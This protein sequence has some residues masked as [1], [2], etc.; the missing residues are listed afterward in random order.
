MYPTVDFIDDETGDNVSVY[1]VKLNVASN[2]R[3]LFDASIITSYNDNKT[4][5]YNANDWGDNVT[6]DVSG[7]SAV[8]PKA[9]VGDNISFIF[10]NYIL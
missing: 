4:C 2:T 3:T 1:E 6:L 10:Y 9:N 8:N 7:C 5:D